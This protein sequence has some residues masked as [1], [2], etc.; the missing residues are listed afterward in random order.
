MLVI[1]H[2]RDYD[3]WLDWDPKLDNVVRSEA[4]R[5]RNKLDAYAAN[6]S[7]DDTYRITVPKGGYVADFT[8]IRSVLPETTGAAHT[9][10]GTKF[11]SLEI[12]VEPC[13]TDARVY[14]CSR[15]NSACCD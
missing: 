13:R 12:H 1:L 6:Q 3:R 4:R 9:A 10:L 14:R 15:D 2:A 7:P 5:L 11:P 8:E